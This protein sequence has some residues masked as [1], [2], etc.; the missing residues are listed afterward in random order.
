[1]KQLLLS[2]LFFSVL[3]SCEENAAWEN[4][5]ETLLNKAQSITCELYDLNAQTDS[6]WDTT[7][8]QMDALLP[9]DMNADDR[10]NMLNIRN[11]NLI[12]TFRIY[13]S[14]D[15]ELHAL[16]DDADQKDQQLVEAI[17]NAK[18]RFDENDAAIQN[19]L[20]NLETQTT[21]E[22]YLSWR[23]RFN[24]ITCTN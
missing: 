24:E 22:A 20:L 1:M 2:L 6:L 10:R 18:K 17:R 14:L 16:I 5:A 4:E 19:F 7:V 21:P 13:K 11:A 12:R 23:Q 3:F 9:L 15:S 8:V